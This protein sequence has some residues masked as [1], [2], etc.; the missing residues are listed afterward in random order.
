MDVPA[1]VEIVEEDDEEELQD[2]DALLER[3]DIQPD[4]EEES[5]TQQQVET[6]QNHNQTAETTEP[7]QP[8]H[9]L[10]TPR[11][12]YY[13]TSGQ[14]VYGHHRETAWHSTQRV[15]AAFSSFPG[16]S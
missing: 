4:I 11:G 8:S 10:H 6:I 7:P 5:A 13:N 12:K 9:T 3:E 15:H 2:L 16:Q 1:N 14:G